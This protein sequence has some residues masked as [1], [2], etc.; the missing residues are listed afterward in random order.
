MNGKLGRNIAQWMKIENKNYDEWKIE[1]LNFYK[2]W[3]NEKMWWL[4]YPGRTL[5]INPFT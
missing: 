1:K 5:S 4:I 2:E 3:N